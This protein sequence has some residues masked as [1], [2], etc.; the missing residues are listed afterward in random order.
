MERRKPLISLV[1]VEGVEPS[2]YYVPP[3]FESGA[4]ASSTTPAMPDS[5]AFFW[6][7]Q[8]PAPANVADL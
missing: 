8:I 2:R 4:S 7:S 1:P 6:H 3:D 5:K